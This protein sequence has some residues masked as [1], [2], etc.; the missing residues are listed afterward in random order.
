MLFQTYLSKSWLE[1][2]GG[3]HCLGRWHWHRWRLIRR[4]ERGGGLLHS[5]GGLH[6]G[7]L[8][9]F[10]GLI[11]T[12]VSSG[13]FM[14]SFQFPWLLMQGAGLTRLGETHASSFLLFSKNIGIS[15]DYNMRIWRG[16]SEW[17]SEWVS[18]LSLPPL[19][20][21]PRFS[22]WWPRPVPWAWPWP[23]PPGP[24]LWS[25]KWNVTD[26]PRC[27]GVGVFG[28]WQS[29]DRGARRLQSGQRHQCDTIDT[30]SDS[31]ISV[32]IFLSV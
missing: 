1:W 3:C 16:V 26:G 19:R 25:A 29:R 12:K 30:T 18:P 15:I 9:W 17:V 27:L 10:L 31:R 24:S 20:T 13:L 5:R 23:R 8:G 14:K 22:S 21:R 6:R 2:G 11:K 28:W 32:I 4:L 7:S